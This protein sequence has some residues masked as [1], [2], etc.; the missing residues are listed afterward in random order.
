MGVQ[1]FQIIQNRTRLLQ[2]FILLFVAFA[3]TSYAQAQC[4]T[5]V[6][7]ANSVPAIAAFVS[8]VGGLNRVIGTWQGGGQT[9]VLQRRADGSLVGR[10]GNGDWN[11]VRFCAGEA[12]QVRVTVGGNTRTLSEPSPGS[13]KVVVNSLI[14]VSA[15]RVGNAPAVND[16]VA[17]SAGPSRSI[18]STSRAGTR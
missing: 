2:M 12:G 10:S 1:M 16:N 8:K 7:Q 3:S 14:A 17:S 5:N 6:N 11:P 15:T 13:F 9:M 18:A 4:V